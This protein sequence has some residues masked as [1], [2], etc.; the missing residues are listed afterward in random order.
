MN[1]YT[2]ISGTFYFIITLIEGGVKKHV[3]AISLKN[4]YN[5]IFCED[6]RAVLY[7]KKCLPGCPT[8][9]DIDLGLICM[10]SDI[11]NFIP[12]SDFCAQLNGMKPTGVKNSILQGLIDA[13]NPDN[14]NNISKESLININEIKGIK[15]INR[16]N[17]ILNNEFN[18]T[19]ISSSS[20]SSINDG[21]NSTDSTF[22]TS[23]S[24]VD[25]KPVPNLDTKPV[26]Y[27]DT[28]TVQH[29]DNINISNLQPI[30]SRM[31]KIRYDVK[32][33]EETKPEINKQTGK[34][35]EHFSPFLN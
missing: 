18:D 25:I 26:Q 2:S 4:E 17:F 11:S 34:K 24:N 5:P 14:I 30:S 27:F 6:K 28:K 13:C 3:K 15:Q 22:S 20:L 7:N 32:S 12:N 16:N 10:K 29:F 31:D 1:N 35:I 8:G 21:D 9:Y 33:R 19:T 23:F